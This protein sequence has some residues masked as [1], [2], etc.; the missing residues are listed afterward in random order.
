M[1]LFTGVDLHSNNGY[2]G[3]INEKVAAV[4]RGGGW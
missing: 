3:I 1:G 4:N 2:Y